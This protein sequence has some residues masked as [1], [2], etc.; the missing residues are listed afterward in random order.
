MTNS[1][2]FYGL[3]CFSKGK[4]P[5]KI[6]EYS[7]PELHFNIWE[8]GKEVHLDIGLLLDINDPSA[9]LEL[10]FPWQLVGNEGTKP[11]DIE[12][13]AKRI[14]TQD[15]IPA[16]FNESWSVTSRANSTGHV[17]TEPTKNNVLFT[18]V[19]VSTA[20]IAKKHDDSAHVLSINVADLRAKSLSLSSQAPKVY[21]RFRV[22]SVPKNFYCVGIEQKD[23]W[24]LSSWQ[25]TEI[26]DFRLNVRR[27][28]PADLE[29]SVGSFVEFSKVHLFLM[30]SR[31]QDIVFEDTLFKSCRSL[32]DEGFW[33]DYSSS[34]TAEDK[35]RSLTNVNQSIG[36]QWSKRRGQESN[37]TV[38]EFGILA[39]F[40]KVEFGI[41]KFLIWALVLGALG[42]ALWDGTKWIYD[43]L[44]PKAV[45]S[46]RQPECPQ[47]AIVDGM[48]VNQSKGAKK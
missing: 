20:L 39:R 46:I 35:K 14:S 9:S 34:G 41:G 38:K 18:I 40:K 37:A 23:R 2:S 7:R 32:E 11:K 13:L 45:V 27:G 8:K 1:T 31:D 29:Q 10:Y 25:K 26:I 47:S 42:N 24:W 48:P 33:A 3:L 22:K 28:V 5:G 43:T 12:D 17:I 44:S 19:D 21:I 6:E 16:V 15:A 4:S 30:R 36:Y